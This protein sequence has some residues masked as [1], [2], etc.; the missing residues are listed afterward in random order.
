MKNFKKKRI[1]IFFDAE[2]IVFPHFSGIGHYTVSL[3]KA[4][5]DLLDFGEYSHLKITVGV[6]RHDK[7]KLTKFEFKN[8]KVKLTPLTSHRINGLK[9]R[10]M[11]PPID[12]L[13]GKQIYIFP[14]YSSWPTTSFSRSIPIIY[15]L[16]FIKYPQFGDSKNMEFLVEQ[17]ALSIN[18]SDRIITISTNSKKEIREQY[19]Y[20]PDKIDIIY[21]I[22]DNKMFYK[23]SDIEIRRVRAKYGI[24][25]DYILFVGNLEPRKNLITLLA[26]YELLPKELQKKY[27]LLLVGAKGWKDGEIHNKIQS[28]RMDGLRV[29]Q[30]VDYV[31]DEDIPAIVSGSSSFAYV[32]MY[33]GFGIPPV[34]A[35]SCG[36]PVVVSNNSSLPEACGNAAIYVDANNQKEIAKAIERSLVKTNELVQDGYEQ[37]IKFNVQSSAKSFLDTIEKVSKQ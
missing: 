17:V 3:L 31:T 21:P 6:P 11:L 12:L 32:S 37:A 34:E 10:H 2:V 19:N 4:I 35:M 28:M 18:R 26:A 29:I 20:S 7:D 13:F 33:E 16:S 25:D 30:P 5:D 1:K 22:I 27:A 23:R 9:K 14:N 15:D 24:F 8:F 36:V